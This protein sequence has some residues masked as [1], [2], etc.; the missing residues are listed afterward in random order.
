[1]YVM[2]FGN[3]QFS[4]MLDE[5]IEIYEKLLKQGILVRSLKSVR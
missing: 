3:S 1:V 4:G 5:R 2:A